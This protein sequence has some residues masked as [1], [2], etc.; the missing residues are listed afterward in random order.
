MM[1]IGMVTFYLIE[2]ILEWV[3]LGHD[4]EAEPHN[5]KIMNLENKKSVT[6]ET[7]KATV[8]EPE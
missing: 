4:H 1:I 6:P 8:T 2:R 7:P 3:G 5:D